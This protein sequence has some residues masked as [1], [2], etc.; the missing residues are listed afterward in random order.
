[1]HPSVFE[2]FDRICRVRGAGGDV[3]EIGAV[4]SGDSLLCLP[5]LRG[6][7]SKVGVNL[8]G[9]LAYADFEV[10]AVDAN[11]MRCFPDGSFDTVLTNSVL[12]HDRYFWRTLAEIERV[13]R[14]GAL[15]VIGVPGFEKLAVE[16]LTSRA[17]RLPVVGTL[18][19]RGLPMALASTLT[20]H[21]H[22]FPADYYRF[23][24]RA[25]RE[26]FLERLDDAEVRTV[27]VPPRI[28]AAG[29]KRRVAGKGDPPRAPAQ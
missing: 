14:P 25:A 12:E 6:A 3:L 29:V 4:A 15:V 10:R 22:D 23:S 17:A 28:L 18:L 19:R 16:R 8:E 26:V 13:A 5:S 24:A 21:V 20:L 7:R 27:L 2:E 9:P 11:D 1:M